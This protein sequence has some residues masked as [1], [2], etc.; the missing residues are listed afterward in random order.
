MHTRVGTAEWADAQLIAEKYRFEK[1]KFWLGRTAH[2]GLAPL[3]YHDDR[4]ICLVS[5]SRGGKGTTT[6]INNLCMWPGSVVVVDPKG[7]N[8]SVTAQRRGK[9]SEYCE[10]MGQAVHVLDPFR[11]ANVP[12][13]YRSR[14]N[15]LDALDPFDDETID[16]AARLADALVVVR[17]DS[18]DP[19]WDESARAMVKGLILYVL[20]AT[21]FEG[22]RNLITVRE[23]ITRGDARGI[24]VL[25]E[26]GEES[27]PSAQALLWEGVRNNLRFDGVV[28]GIGESFASMLEASPKQFESVLQ[29]ANRNTE[30]LDS[31]GMRRCLS[32][33]DFSL[34]DLKTRPEGVSLY[35]S[36]PQR[37]MNTHYRWLRMMISLTVTEMEKVKGKPATGHRILMCLDE[38]AGLKRMEVI[39]NAVAQ[40]ASYGVTMFFVLQSLEQLKSAYKDNWETFL[41]NFGLKIFYNLDDHFSREYVS[42]FMGETELIREVRTFSQGTTEGESITENES[43]SRGSSKG[44]GSGRN[45]GRNDGGGESYRQPLLSA[46]RKDRS[47]SENSGRQTGSSSQKN[48]GSSVSRTVGKAIGRTTGTSETYGTNETIQKRALATPDEIGKQF[49][50]INDKHDQTYPGLALV[51]ISGEN[52]IALKRVNY[53]EDPYFWGWFDPHPDHGWPYGARKTGRINVPVETYYS[54]VLYYC[55]DFRR[56]GKLQIHWCVEQGRKVKKNQEIAYV[57]LALEQ[58]NGGIERIRRADICAPESGILSKRIVEEGEEITVHEIRTIGVITSS[59]REIS[60]EQHMPVALPLYDN[61]VPRYLFR[62]PTGCLMIPVTF[63]YACMLLGLAISF[64]VSLLTGN[65]DEMR[66]EIW[67]GMLATAI[68][69]GIVAFLEHKTKL[70]FEARKQERQDEMTVRAKNFYAY[71]RLPDG[72]DLNPQ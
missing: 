5:G 13:E 21:E 28:A 56:R 66:A 9:G 55:L 29:T 7:E 33:S 46:V 27:L 10:G 25:R 22:H 15:P 2:D 30:F 11:V 70:F 60:S 72:K 52:P 48:W 59:T 61:V 23:L 19:F 45:K 31:P 34:S 35:L 50:R 54:D 51:L 1:G 40:I 4:H 12:D 20:T 41:A 14:F 36:L 69:G 32:A 62:M 63:F 49:A 64:L 68:F 6:I 16:E 17:S 53:Y 58:K 57:V 37:F 26:M 42:K 67:L 8:A 71:A 3:G 43:V 65:K 18:K 44:G 24:E 47:Y 38:F 39:E